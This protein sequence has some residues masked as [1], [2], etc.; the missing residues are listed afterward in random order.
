MSKFGREL[1]LGA[2]NVQIFPFL[3]ATLY[4]VVIR[5]WQIELAESFSGE[6]LTRE[7]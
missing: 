4:N 7:K 3:C 5:N 2:K 6:K 1:I